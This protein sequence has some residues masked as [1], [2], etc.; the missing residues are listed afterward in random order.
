MHSRLNPLK[1]GE[2]PEQKE[3]TVMACL[4]GL[5]PLKSGEV[6]EPRS[7]SWWLNSPTS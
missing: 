5:N 6:P 3:V 7:S 1:S 2:V 4:I